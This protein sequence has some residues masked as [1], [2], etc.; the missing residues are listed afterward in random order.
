[1]V[2]KNQPTSQAAQAAPAPEPRPAPPGI[3]EVKVE[4]DTF[5]VEIDGDRVSVDGEELAVR[6]LDATRP[7]K[8][9]RNQI[10]MICQASGMVF[11]VRCREGDHVKEGETLLI[12]ES[13]KMEMSVK[14]PVDGTVVDLPVYVGDEVSSGQVLAVIKPGS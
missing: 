8:K 1:M 6:V 12:L 7:V 2:R 4:G 13:L 14:A 5:E 9:R 10:R 3:Y 11:K